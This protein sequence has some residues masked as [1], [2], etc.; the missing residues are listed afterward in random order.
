MCK[1]P[2]RFERTEQRVL[3]VF[4]SLWCLKAA[5][6]AKWM[7]GLVLHAGQ[8]HWLTA[9]RKSL[10]LSLDFANV[11]KVRSS[12]WKFLVEA[13][14]SCLFLLLLFLLLLNQRTRTQRYSIFINLKL[15][16]AVILTA[17]QL[18][19]GLTIDYLFWNKRYPYYSLLTEFIWNNKSKNR[20]VSWQTTYWEPF[21]VQNI[22]WFLLPMVTNCWFSVLQNNQLNISEFWSVK[23]G[24]KA[25]EEDITSDFRNLMMGILQEIPEEIICSLIIISY[26][27]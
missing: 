24:Q 9:N 14:L 17:W 15:R 19:F 2:Q 18:L 7:K 6:S 25:F 3:R 4:E 16:T 11:L 20:Q 1:E 22:I 23:F 5:K 10:C 26:N 27:H 12:I 8:K 21:F 13:A